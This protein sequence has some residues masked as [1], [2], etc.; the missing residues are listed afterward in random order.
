MPAGGI[1]TLTGEGGAF[2]GIG[3]ARLVNVGKLGW[4]LLLFLSYIEIHTHASICMWMTL[5][6]DF[7]NLAL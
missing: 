1:I 5:I 6:F 2:Q 7:V 3:D 4:L